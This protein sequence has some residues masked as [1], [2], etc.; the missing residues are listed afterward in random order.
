MS[1][2]YSAGT[3][4]S[5][6]LGRQ[7]PNNNNKI[8]TPVDINLRNVV[9]IAA[10]W[11]HNVIVYADG[12]VVGWGSNTDK[13]IGLDQRK[14]DNLPTVIDT[15]SDVKIVW[16]SC[17]DK[18]TSFLTDTGVVYIADKK[19][20]KNR[21]CKLNI[22]VQCCYCA[23]GVNNTYSIGIDG[24]LYMS[25]EDPTD[26]P[27]HFTFPKPIYD[28]AGGDNFA[29]AVTV[30]HVA[31][32]YG[33]IVGCKEFKPIAS[34][35]NVRVLRVF[36]YNQHAAVIDLDG[37]T[38]TWG[39]G[40]N[41]RLGHG[42]DTSLDAFKVVEKLKKKKVVDIDMGDSH[43]VFI[44]SEGN[45]YACGA[46]DDGRLMLGESH[47]YTTPEHSKLI[48][49][50]AVYATCGC[51]HTYVLTGDSYIVHPGMRKFLIGQNNI[52]T[53]QVFVFGD[54]EINI[55]YHSMLHLGFFPGDIVRTTDKIGT[56]F[57]LSGT[58]KVAVIFGDTIEK[59]RAENLAFVTRKG[60]VGV[61]IIFQNKQL[62]VDGGSILKSYGL[63]CGEKLAD[64]TN[65]QYIV[66]GVYCNSIYL[67]PLEQ[68]Q[69][70][71]SSP[72]PNSIAIEG[73]LQEFFSNFTLIESKR[74][75]CNIEVNNVMYPC[76]KIEPFY[77][78]LPEPILV[79]GRFSYFYVG[80]NYKKET[81]FYKEDQAPSL[82]TNGSFYA[83]D[84]VIYNNQRALI[85][86]LGKEQ[87]VIFTE[88]PKEKTSTIIVPNSKLTLLTRVIPDS[89]IE[90]ELEG[91]TG[92]KKLSNS[93]P[94]DI[95][96]T[97]SQL[98]CC[99]GDLFVGN[100]GFVS[101]LGYYKDENNKNDPN[102]PYACLLSDL[103][104]QSGTFKKPFIF[105]V[106]N[107]KL[108]RKIYNIG[109]SNVV[110]NEETIP[111]IL[112]GLQTS[113]LG[114]GLL[115]GDEVLVDNDNRAVVCGLKEHYLWLKSFDGEMYCI[116]TLDSDFKGRITF[117]QRPTSNYKILL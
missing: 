62:T 72:Y 98:K 43:T 74:E 2:L 114:T 55:G 80:S 58:S 47:N 115:Q 113:M 103:L 75:F 111:I 46:S 30:D 51:F 33:K 91:Q 66:L 19:V 109:Y 31:Y 9:C 117:V 4:S 38:Y 26:D 90:T 52:P 79:V 32:G 85:S 59:V 100:E 42:D 41:G 53:S 68:K 24:S 83:F 12:T 97:D 95:K 67:E 48:K 23:C 44:D 88:D 49:G 78:H 8:P 73:S 70:P 16:A 11:Q 105:K 39:N 76:E 112:S 7:T 106:E 107:Y 93:L 101:I 45:V 29:L 64:T 65:K 99:P 110:F 104:N 21:P 108:V 14:N 92:V 1:I 6:R 34:L 57:G 20:P 50:H 27:V 17:G 69:D 102:V 56:V 18:I 81:K 71:S 61:P 84:S 40:S 15:L 35:A 37:V 13:Q 5:Y 3:S 60:Y 116:Q 89:F 87:S 10:G 82:E 77:L 25:S 63:Q 36:G 94:Y 54:D 28:V 22:P 86:S 96:E